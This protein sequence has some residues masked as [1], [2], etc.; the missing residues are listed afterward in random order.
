MEGDIISCVLISDWYQDRMIFKWN[1]VSGQPS[2][3]LLQ[4]QSSPRKIVILSWGAQHRLIIIIIF[5]HTDITHFAAL[6]FSKLHTALNIGARLPRT[7]GGCGLEC[8][9]TLIPNTITCNNLPLQVP[10][11]IQACRLLRWW[12]RRRR[13][14]REG[15]RETV[16]YL[17]PA[18]PVKCVC[19][20]LRT[21]L[22]LWINVYEKYLFLYLIIP[23]TFIH[24][25]YNT[26]NPA[27]L[28]LHVGAIRCN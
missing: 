3:K 19:S 1:I 15:G 13:G 27:V 20:T 10:L 7:S 17:I 16:E 2:F 28:Y 22:H 23:A 21:C 14:G 24:S 6:L 26:S 18:E 4:F 9:I 11:P 5:Q 8:V 25:N 12:R